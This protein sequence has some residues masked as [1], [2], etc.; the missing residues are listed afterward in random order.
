MNFP[1]RRGALFTDLKAGRQT[2][3]GYDAMCFVRFRHDALSD[4][5]RQDRQKDFMMAFKETVKKSPDKFPEVTNRAEE[6]LN[7][8]MT[9]SEI[10]ALG[11]FMQSV[12]NDNIT[13]AAVPTLP[14]RGSNLN[15]DYPKLPEILST[16]YLTNPLITP[17]TERV[18]QR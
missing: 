18:S 9:S 5:A 15:L 17:S 16:T 13:M 4:F 1:A 6:V 14:G 8:A 3:N 7:G 12:A 10:A 2:L 11:R